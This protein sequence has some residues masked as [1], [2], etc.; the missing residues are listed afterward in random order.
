MTRH[1]ARP[2]SRSIRSRSK[3]SPRA[4]REERILLWGGLVLLGAALIVAWIAFQGRTL[5]P[6]APSPAATEVFKAKGPR[7]VF[8]ETSFDFG[9]VPLDKLV[10]H[11]F[12]YRNVGDAPVVLQGKPKVEL[13]EGC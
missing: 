8:D 2:S 1:K 12:V 3:G 10:E 9:P 6:G 5:L 4:R 13:V 11:D 7:L